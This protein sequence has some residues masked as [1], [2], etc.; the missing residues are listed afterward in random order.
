MRFLIPVLN[1]LPKQEIIAALPKLIKLNPIVVKEVMFC[2]YGLVFVGSGQ[3]DLV[4]VGNM[5]GMNLVLFD[6]S[7]DTV[8]ACGGSSSH[9]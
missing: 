1:G 3:S 6:I 9:T 5:Y 8:K 7:F 2:H 4:L